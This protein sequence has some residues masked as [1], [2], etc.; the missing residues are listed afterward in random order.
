MRSESIRRS[1]FLSVAL[2][3]SVLITNGSAQTF[4]VRTSGDDDNSGTSAS[5]A[6]AT[7]DRAL[8]ASSTPY[9]IVGAGEYLVDVT[10][11]MP[12]SRIIIIGDKDGTRTGDAGK[13][14]FKSNNNRY[15][16]SI[17]NA[18]SLYVAS[19][20]F[21]SA[22]AGG[23]GRGIEASSLTSYVYARECEFDDLW[24]GVVASRCGYYYGYRNNFKN[25]HYAADVSNCTT[26]YVNQSTFAN[27]HRPISNRTIDNVRLLRTNIV[28]PQDN[29]STWAVTNAGVVNCLL[30]ECNIEGSQNG[31]VICSD[32]QWITLSGVSVKGFTDGIRLEAERIDARNVTLTGGTGKVGSGLLV[33]GE[34]QPS[35]SNCV[36]NEFYYGITLD[37]PKGLRASGIELG[38]NNTGF[39]VGSKSTDIELDFRG[40]EFRD[41]QT[42]VLIDQRSADK[43]AKLS[44]IVSTSNRT[45]I[46]ANVGTLDVGNSQFTSCHRAI[47]HTSGKR[48][49][50][51]NVT[52]SLLSEAGATGLQLATGD[53]TIRGIEIRGGDFGIRLDL[54]D[55][56]GR[57]AMRSVA[58][59]HQTQH[60]LNVRN[61]SLSLGEGDNITITDANYGIV[62]TQTNLNANGI[63]LQA[64]LGFSAQYGTLSIDNVH[65]ISGYQ[66]VVARRLDRIVVNNCSAKDFEHSGLYFEA[67]K[68]VILRDV[69]L[70]NARDVMCYYT[71]RFDASG[72]EL[73]GSQYGMYLY[74]RA[75]PVEFN[76]RDCLIDGPSIG[77]RT[78]RFPVTPE[79]VQGLSFQNCRYALRTEYENTQITKDSRI[80]FKNNLIACTSIRGEI[81]L[82]G[83]DIDETNSYGLYAY[84]GGA[85]VDS[86]NIGAKTYGVLLYGK[87]SKILNSQFTNSNY[88]IFFTPIEKATLEIENCRMQPRTMGVYVRGRRNIVAKA[89]IR[90]TEVDAGTYGLY[91]RDMDIE[92]NNITLLNSKTSGIYSDNCNSLHVG[93]DV[94]GSGNWAG[95]WRRG[96]VKLVR[97]KLNSR[98]GVYLAAEKGELINCA[99]SGGFYGAY[100]YGGENRILQ[101]TFGNIQGRGIYHHG[102]TLELRNTIVDSRQYGLYQ[103]SQSLTATHDYNLINGDRLSYYNATQSL[104]EIEKQPIFVNA[105]QGDLHLAAG[106]PAINSGQDL[107]AIASTDIEG[108]ARPSFRQFEMGAY[109]FMENAGSLRVLEWAEQAQ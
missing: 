35:L 81:E 61:G 23:Q 26:S 27:C 104:H 41:N 39:R 19:I 73:R 102:G 15:A 93:L 85:T 54:L 83:T 77:V 42:A 109:E 45:G 25:C 48:T 62:S 106:S 96:S 10:R 14:V 36:A 12:G 55:N 44:N 4:Y 63:K 99:V 98:Q 2:V 67:N 47:V 11:S 31:G 52:T 8:Q 5:Q 49:S 74:N 16:L 56:N 94:K 24:S 20:A 88:S 64:R 66:M 100:C 97:A 78:V 30:L 92:S 21:Q 3:I 51:E 76:L 79:H 22:I 65:C 103:R 75:A 32:T 68:E 50:V 69:S 9:I 108:N 58:L 95:S 17:R 60:A 29:S 46:V 37:G 71:D 1:A 34:A 59:S 57:G 84:Y 18:R 28:Q 87:N 38:E 70:D 33:L 105:T 7:I 43:S 82:N 40:C 86:C 101:S 53:A 80:S 89:H 13:V 90:D 91:S 107:S 6:F 72:L